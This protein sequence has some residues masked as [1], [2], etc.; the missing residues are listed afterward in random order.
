MRVGFISGTSIARST[1]FDDWTPERV[2]TRYGPVSVKARDDHYL[3]NR[4]GFEV[5]VPPHSINYRAN[6]Q[7]MED[8]GVEAIVSLQSVGSLK[9]DLPPGTI[10]S[11]DDYVSFAPI[12]FSDDRATAFAPN[13]PNNLVPRIID[14][15]DH[16]ILTGKVYIQ[17]RGPRFETKA[18]VRILE[19]WGD[20][21]G[22]TMA[23]EADLAN[24]LGIPYNSLCM[25]DN[26]AHGFEGE[27]LSEEAFHRLVAVNLEKVQTLFRCMLM[28]LA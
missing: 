24:E 27:T 23:H 18:E 6:L 26:Y 7:L 5:P 16:E 20:V 3:I 21:V 19:P 2:E 22:M 10:V 9:R 17:T 13:V 28:L 12:T 15:F 4:H 14:A 8:L 25:I 11:C 1:L